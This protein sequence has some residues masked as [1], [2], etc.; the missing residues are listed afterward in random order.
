MVPGR[1]TGSYMQM[2][3]LPWGGEGGGGGTYVIRS[4]RD[5]LAIHRHRVRQMARSRISSSR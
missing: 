5:C 4:Q 2:E 1:L 3:S